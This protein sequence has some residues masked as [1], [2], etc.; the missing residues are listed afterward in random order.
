MSQNPAPG[1]QVSCS[2]KDPVRPSE[3]V[4]EEQTD[5]DQGFRLSW[6]QEY[7]VDLSDTLASIDEINIGFQRQVVGVTITEYYNR[8]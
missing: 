6:A 2:S 3:P 7:E 8:K 1:R 4:M 5:E